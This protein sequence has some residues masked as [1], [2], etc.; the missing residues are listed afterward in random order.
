MAPLDSF[1]SVNA[2]NTAAPPVNNV[3]RA[4][5]DDEG[6]TDGTTG[7]PDVLA[8]GDIRQQGCDRGP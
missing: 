2:A 5:D 4:G 3:L 1:G 6:E 8:T 7:L